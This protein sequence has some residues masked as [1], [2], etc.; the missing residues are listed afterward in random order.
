MT[1]KFVKEWRRVVNIIK[2]RL[3]LHL[4]I[5]KISFSFLLIIMRFSILYY[6]LLLT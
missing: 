3:L 6:L 4:N 2:F 1:A 5:L